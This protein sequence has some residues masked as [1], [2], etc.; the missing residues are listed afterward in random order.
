MDQPSF[1]G[2][3]DAIA[4]WRMADDELAR[5]DELAG[6]EL[7][8][9]GSPVTI[10]EL[11]EQLARAKQQREQAYRLALQAMKSHHDRLAL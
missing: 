8:A 1:S 9:G 10:R 11:G 7:H 4:A 5:L 6:Q 2:I 3:I